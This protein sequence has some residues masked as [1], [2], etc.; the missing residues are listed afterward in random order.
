MNLCQIFW[1]TKKCHRKQETLCKINHTKCQT[2]PKKKC[3][4]NLSFWYTQDIVYDFEALLRITN[5]RTGKHDLL[6]I[7]YENKELITEEHRILRQ[8]PS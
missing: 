5:K 3:I 7:D 1:E 2:K 4:S 6:S 8:E